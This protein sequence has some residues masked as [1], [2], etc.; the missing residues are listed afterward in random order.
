MPINS[1]LLNKPKLLRKLKVFYDH[2]KKN[3][4]KIGTFRRGIEMNYNNACNLRCKYCFTNSPKGEGVKK[5]LPL[6]KIQ[7]IAD[8][9]DELG[10]IEWDLQGGELLLWPDKLF[11]V[12][13]AI[14]P[15]RF[16]LYL[17]T[18]GWKMDKKM[19]QKLAKHHV[20]RISVSIDSMN[21]E[22]HDDLRGRKD[23]WRK[24]MEALKIV[25]EAGIDPYLNITVGHY[26][27]KSEDLR[28]LLEYSKKNRYRTLINV[29]CPAG[30]WNKVHDEVC[31]EDDREHL[32]KLRKEF[33]N[34]NRNIW[35]PFDKNNEKIIGCTTVNRIYITP[36]G[37]VLACPYVHIKIGNVFEKSLKEITD[38]GFRIKHFRNHSDKCL[39]GEDLNFIKNFNSS[40]GKSIFKPVDA[41]KIFPKEDFVD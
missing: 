14:K 21:P 27:A 20:G 26:N 22:I 38:Y 19:A 37:D 31:D 35:N 32:K 15:E 17:T 29:A 24:A 30:M 5:F 6:S 39:A 2:L 28:M 12:L 23:S 41:N 18:N 8:E 9:A 13:E 3:D 25:Q 10:Y 11:D 7:E 1:S 34:L 4:G 40:E 36:V 16:Y 33:K